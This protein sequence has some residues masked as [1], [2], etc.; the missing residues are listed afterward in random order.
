MQITSHHHALPPKV[1]ALFAVF[2]VANLLHFVHNA[3]YIEFYP[4][5]PTWLTR[6]KVYL[7]WLAGAGMG[8]SGLLLC[9]TQLNLLGMVL[10][11]AFGALGIDGL[12]HYTLALCS[13]H[14]LATNLTIWFEVLTGLALLLV[15]ASLIGRSVS[16]HIAALNKN[17][18]LI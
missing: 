4:G 16:L 17:S 9:K 3:Q 13:E 1:Q 18:A 10:V 2:F 11:A 15:C 12:A 7:A 6:E 5:I 14:T 8:L